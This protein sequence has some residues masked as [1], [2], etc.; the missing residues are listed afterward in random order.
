MEIPIVNLQQAKE[1]I[2][3]DIAKACVKWGFFQV[4][5]HKI[6]PVLLGKVLR[7]TQDFFYSQRENKV[8][9]FRSKENARGYFD[10]ELTKRRPDYKEAY[11]VGFEGTFEI[12]G[13]NR[14]PEL[15]LHFRPV[16]QEYIVAVDKLAKQ[17]LRYIAESLDLAPEALDGDFSQNTSFL[18]MNFY[19]LCK[20]KVVEE[21]FDN[22]EPD[23]ARDGVLSVN[24]HTDAGALTVLLHRE[25]DPASLQVFS[26]DLKKFIRVKPLSNSFII[27]IGDVI[28]VWSNDL[29]KS[30]VHR[31]L[32]NASKV[33]NGLLYTRNKAH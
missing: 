1:V 3:H 7:V 12:D 9:V 24:R 13:K 22:Q 17:V 30:P 27:N 16:I 28:Q 18:R 33:R 25:G 11:D 6:D 20:Q 19:P 10:D 5:N 32:A 26:R 15:P 2:V 23:S 14:W 29:Y 4:I 31:V 21:H 8:G